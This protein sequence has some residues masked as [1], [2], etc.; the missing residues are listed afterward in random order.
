M[1]L[2]DEPGKLFVDE[3][4]PF[5]VQVAVQDGIYWLRDFPNHP[6]ANIL[7]QSILGYENWACTACTQCHALRTSQPE[8][9]YKALSDAV[10]I[11]NNRFARRQDQYKSVLT[12]KL[13]TVEKRNNQIHREQRELFQK[14][15]HIGNGLDT[16]N[17]RMD[18]MSNRLNSI[19]SL[20][21]QGT[22]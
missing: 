8:S 6:C 11:S 19:Y 13:N 1:P 9:Q 16:V 10:V 4:L 15:W 18:N 14:V 20:L 22:Y 7:K 3:L 21:Q 12:G 5:L 17:T 2:G